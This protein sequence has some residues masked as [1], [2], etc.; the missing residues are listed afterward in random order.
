MLNINLRLPRKV[1]KTI[2]SCHQNKI[3]M[4][5]KTYVKS[6]KKLPD[7]MDIN[8]ELALIYYRNLKSFHEAENCFK[9]SI[10]LNS[11]REDLYKK[12]FAK[13][14]KLKNH[15]NASDTFMSLENSRNAF[16][17]DRYMLKPAITSCHQNKISMSIKTY[18]KS[19]KKLPD[20]MDINLE[21]ALIYYRNLKSFHE[22]ENCFK[23]SIKLNSKREDLYKKLFAKFQ[24]L[25][26]HINASDTFMSLGK[27]Q[28]MHLLLIAIT[29]CHQDKISMS[30][31]TYVKSLKKLPD[32]MD[33]NLELALIYYRNLKSFHEAEN[34]FKK[35]IKLNSKREDLYKKLFAKFQ[36]L[37]N[38]IN[39]SDTF[40]SLEN[41]RN[42][43]TTDRYMLKP[44]ITSCHQDKISMSIKTYVKS[45]KKLPDD[46][47]I[48][49]E[50]ALIYYRNLKSFH[51]AENCFKKSIKLN[52]KREDLYKKL[53]A[54]FQ[55][56]KNHI[57]A[58]DT[59][60]VVGLPRKVLKTITSCHQDKISMSIKTY[61]KSLKKLPDDMDINLEL[62]LIYYRN[63]KSFHEAENC[64]KKSI[65]LNSKREDLYKKLLAKF[66]KLKNH[67]N[68]SDTFMSLENSRNA[69]TT[70]RYM[71]KPAITSCHQNKI[72]MSIKTY[73]KSL[74][75]LPDDMDINLELALIYYRNLKSFH[76]AE[77]C[78]K[79][80]IKLN[81]KREDLYK[82]L[83]AKFQKLKNHINASDTFIVVGLPRKVLKT[84]TSCHQD[85][86]SMSI[87]TY[88]KS[89]K[90][91]P[92][93]M[94][95][96]LELA[97]IY[98]RNLKSFHEAENC[99]KK[100][101]K[102]NSKREDLYKKLLAKFQKLKNH[103]NASDTFM[104]LE[105]S[106]N[107]FTTDRYMLKPAV[108]SCHQDKISMSIKTYV[109]SLKK[110]PD[111]MD[112]NLE[113]AL[114]YYRNLKSFHEAENC[115]KKSIK[116]N[117][118]RE[119]LYKKLFAKFQKKLKECIYYYA[120][121]STTSLFSMLDFKRWSHNHHV[122]AEFG[123]STLRGTL[124]FLGELIGCSVGLSSP[125]AP[126]GF[127]VDVGWST[128]GILLPLFRFQ[129][130]LVIGLLSHRTSIGLSISSVEESP[131]NFIELA[132][133]KSSGLIDVNG[134]S[135]E[136][137]RKDEE[138][139][140]LLG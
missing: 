40:M 91:L 14:Q 69:F 15:I 106:R 73:V 136:R 115:F 132:F 70:D 95:I 122:A 137:Y 64:F 77:N 34:C 21:L 79:K 89:L 74:K 75:K 23:K 134:I 83:F 19:L 105:N 125:V 59:F 55:K 63:L 33:I 1:L 123:S 9:K 57:N 118:K 120:K 41:S 130:R 129:L 65:K 26:N 38:H 29:S 107:A 49:L 35:S 2:T 24:K 87:K 53:F 31:K 131:L 100:S 116:L 56:L 85:K 133:S 7:D 71:L 39:A 36:K 92:D 47:D 37:K 127:M 98:Y 13:F 119:D 103:I 67:I 48:N 42:A 109:K 52:S 90:K 121:Y 11:K 111:D 88:V 93:D 30:I 78:F 96:N 80:S 99:F 62:A 110:L 101:I 58:S 113:L 12:L 61:V 139:P 51:E 5:I 102:L 124:H 117:S 45:L 6:L 135:S 84:I 86:I 3:S 82:K 112:I 46:M 20:D 50:L 8:L 108:T 76:E 44:A 68:A 27:T 66:Q 60:I 54:K 128:Q 138:N 72:S 25:K 10:K 28:G 43:F 32:D 114:I 81:S 126:I 97:L 22:A 16:T 94:D 140:G 18:V 104:S 4:S 17:T